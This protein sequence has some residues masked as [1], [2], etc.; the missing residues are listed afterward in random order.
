MFV[1]QG[2]VG[3]GP[4]MALG[5]YSVGRIESL[6]LALALDA[7]DDLNVEDLLRCLAAP[8]TESSRETLGGA[9]KVLF[10]VIDGVGL[11]KER[12]ACFAF[13]GAPDRPI[14]WFLEGALEGLMAQ[15][16]VADA[17]EW[18]AV[19]TVCSVMSELRGRE[20]EESVLRQAA[21]KHQEERASERVDVA[22]GLALAAGR[23]AEI[24]DALRR[25]DRTG[26]TSTAWVL[27]GALA[28]LSDLESEVDLDLAVA[29]TDGAWEGAVAMPDGGPVAGWEAMAAD[30]LG[31]ARRE[32]GVAQAG[33]HAGAG[34]AE[35]VELDRFVKLVAAARAAYWGQG[36]DDE[37]A[38]DMLATDLCR[39]LAAFPA[40]G[41][42][43]NLL[44]LAAAA[45]L[46][47]GFRGSAL[48]WLGVV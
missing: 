43:G 23:Q 42:G 45:L 25:S 21:S 8:G 31:A 24:L 39:A 27:R 10:D 32:V 41:S 29:E 19:G 44:G 36:H 11:G 14:G 47:D 33:N 2:V 35:S 1:V 46:K 48:E 22:L 5:G 13:V 15:A 7:A 40:G 16:R 20:A 6:A 28:R 4:A 17:G 26:S 12:A 37:A 3:G 38:P 30:D 34:V 18:R 9:A